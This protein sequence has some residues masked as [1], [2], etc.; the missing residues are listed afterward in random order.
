[1]SL[2]GI[3]GL[4]NLLEEMRIFFEF[5]PTAL[6]Q[7]KHRKL[8][9]KYSTEALTSSSREKFFF[10]VLHISVRLFFTTM[11]LHTSFYFEPNTF[12][13]PHS[14]TEGISLNPRANMRDMMIILFP[15]ST[16]PYYMLMRLPY[17]TTLDVKYWRN[18]C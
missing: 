12:I 16:F 14:Y 4:I 7:S 8:C 1:M 11:Y 6:H 18:G 2:S 15:P 10:L 13:I 9:H 5:I 17:F 3:S